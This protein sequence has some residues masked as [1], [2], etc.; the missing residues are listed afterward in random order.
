[1]LGILL[2]LQSC[3]PLQIHIS[4]F[5][6]LKMNILLVNL[7]VT[8]PYI[9]LWMS[10]FSDKI[11]CYPN[12]WW[13]EALHTDVHLHLLSAY[14]WNK[15]YIKIKFTAR[16]TVLLS[17]CYGLHF[18]L[19]PSQHICWCLRLSALKCSLIWRNCGCSQNEIMKEYIELPNMTGILTK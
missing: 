17:N 15:E 3:H 11:I 12:F 6:V 9:W 2:L 8:C 13:N 16:D 18:I 10:K 14:A 19:P 5:C 4:A 7:S 1:M